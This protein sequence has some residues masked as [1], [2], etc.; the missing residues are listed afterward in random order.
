MSR[1]AYAVAAST[2]L[3]ALRTRRV[4]YSPRWATYGPLTGGG[5]NVPGVV[6][7]EVVVFVLGLLVAAFTLWSAMLTVVV[8]RAE[9]ALLSRVHFLTI[10]RIFEFASRRLSFGLSKDTIMS[11]YAPVALILLPVMWGFHVIVGF[12]AMFWALGTR[13]IEDALIVSGSSLTTL[14]FVKP[15]G[16]LSE[17]LAIFEAVIGLGLVALLISYLP[18]MYGEFAEREHVVAHLETRAGRPPTPVVM[19]PRMHQIGM[20]EGS[21]GDVFWAQWERW[22]IDV[23]ETH[24]SHPALVFFRSAYPGRSWVTSAGAA[25]DA[26]AISISSVDVE[27]RPAEMI[28]M[29]S[30]FIALRNIADF[31]GYDIDHDPQP[32]DPIS[33]SRD[34]FESV[35]DAIAAEGVPMKADRDQAWRDF[36]GWRVNYDAALIALCGLVDAPPAAWSSD[37]ITERAPARFFGRRARA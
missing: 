29:R 4:T 22:F 20:L 7:V 2:P 5:G 12:A 18:T 34:E 11:R 16:G 25:L 6:V 35:V 1:P 26:A 37:R 21:D 3:S 9:N 15:D 27:P 31:F 8:P 17:G 23:E 33:I 24:T 14:G 32:S 19:L 36:A 28:M 30:G 13:G 10:R